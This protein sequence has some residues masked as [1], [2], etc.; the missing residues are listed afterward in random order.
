[1]FNITADPAEKYNLIQD[2][3]HANAVYRMK[4]MLQQAGDVAPPWLEAQ[5][6]VNKHS[7]EVA[8]GLCN[9]AHK[10]GGVM[11]IDA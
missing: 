6:L 11:P 1:M 8:K 2:K 3:Q 5:E 4:E 10:M 9:A 7:D